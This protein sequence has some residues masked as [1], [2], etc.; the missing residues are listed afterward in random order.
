MASADPKARG[1]FVSRALTPTQAAVLGLIVAGG[2]FLGIWGLFE[3]GE[4][5]KLWSENIQLEVGFPR[6]KGVAVGTPVRVRGLEA[7]VVSGVDLP[8]SDRP[9]A[10]LTL[11]LKLDRKF[12]PL[13]FADATA[14]I[15]QE[16][17]IG[18]KVIEIEPGHPETGPIP[19]GGRLAPRPT[20]ELAD[21]LAQTQG[22][23]ADLRE[24]QGTMGK[25][26]KDDRAYSEVVSALKDTRRMLERSQDAAQSIKQDADAIKRLPVV[27]SYVEDR[28]S[29]LIRPAHERHRQ[30]VRSDELFEPGRAVLTDSGRDKLNELAGWLNGLKPKGSDVVIAAYADPARAP[31]TAAALALTQKQSEVVV[32]YLKDTHKVH[33]LGWWRS[34]DVRPIGLG[35]DPP[36]DNEI[37]LP[38]ARIE[39][40]VFVPQA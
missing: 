6:L 17:M 8:A 23:I 19:D 21:L 9:D 11:Q 4:R 39:L 33:K 2:L 10:P 26:L 31:S 29:L 37:G 15:L 36:P 38:A 22:M 3:I 5:Q 40:M 25:L 16:G 1:H 24:G 14:A 12:Q 32:A 13:V 27:R 30:W 35:V 18:A 28:T 20:P 7:G 34:R